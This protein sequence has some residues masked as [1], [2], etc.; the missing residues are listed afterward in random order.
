MSL[1]EETGKRGRLSRDTMY[2]LKEEREGASLLTSD[3]IGDPREASRAMPGIPLDFSLTE[4][5]Q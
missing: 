2:P 4:G 3:C 5:L 1:L